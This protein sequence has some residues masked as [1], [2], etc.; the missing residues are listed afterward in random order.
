MVDLY[1]KH[2][3]FDNKQTARYRTVKP[4]FSYGKNIR[5]STIKKELKISKF[6]K[7]TK[8]ILVAQ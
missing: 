6:I 1:E 8:Y 5:F 4:M 3:K 2:G 7:Q